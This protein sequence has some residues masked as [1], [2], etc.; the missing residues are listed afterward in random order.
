MSHTDTA[1]LAKSI[2]DFIPTV[3]GPVPDQEKLVSA[4]QSVLDE[5]LDPD[6]EPQVSSRVQEVVKVTRY[7]QEQISDAEMRRLALTK[8]LDS[9][10]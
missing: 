1:E 6:P 2:A 10:P 8:A 9:I 4:I 5:K 7:L 3:I